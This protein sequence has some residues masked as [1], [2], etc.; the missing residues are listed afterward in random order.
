MPPS[1][2]TS[3]A[4]V[5]FPPNTRYMFQWESALATGSLSNTMSFASGKAPAMRQAACQGMKGNKGKRQ[6]VM[7]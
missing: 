3:Y 4:N 7:P 5:A 2:P 6:I 1:P